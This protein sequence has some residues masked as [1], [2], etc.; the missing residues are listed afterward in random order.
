[1][2]EMS[3]YVVSVQV[4]REALWEMASKLPFVSS[5]GRGGGAPP[6]TMSV[7]CVS[8]GIVTYWVRNRSFALIW[9]FLPSVLRFPRSF[10]E[11]SSSNS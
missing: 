7:N 8:K 5:P 6:T 1:M 9:L 4:L 3:T 11:L 10:H 2:S